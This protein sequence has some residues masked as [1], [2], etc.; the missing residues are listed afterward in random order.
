MPGDGGLGYRGYGDSPSKISRIQ[1]ASFVSGVLTGQRS[2][3]FANASSE[4]TAAAWSFMLHGKCGY[5]E[6]NGAEGTAGEADAY[7]SIHEYPTPS[8]NCS[9]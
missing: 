9:F 2:A 5:V 3:R 1:Y 4:T 7:P 6:L 8:E